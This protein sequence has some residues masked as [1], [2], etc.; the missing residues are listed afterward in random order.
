MATSQPRRTQR[1]ILQFLIALIGVDPLVWRRIRVSGDYSFWDLHVAIQDAM[2][3][4]DYHLHEFELNDPET[5]LRIKIGLPDDEGLYDWEVLPDHTLHIADYFSSQN[6]QALYTY[7]FGDGWRH[8]LA[9]EGFLPRE[10]GAKYPYCLSGERKCPPEDC[11]GP[12]GY[13]Y[14]LEAVQ[15][16]HHDE[17]D[18]YVTWIGGSF[19][20]ADF[21]PE[22]VHF[23]DP[24][25]RWRIAFNEEY[26]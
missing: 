6:A 8:L 9:F 11:G 24:A 23:Y 26:E 21:R 18:Q 5:G 20:P 25:E 2:G 12:G 4:M 17:H 10:E 14:F 7:D 13:A 19:D 15:D 1:P 16:P 3:W 22:Q